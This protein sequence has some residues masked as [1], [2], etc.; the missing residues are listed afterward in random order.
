VA[1]K[2]KVSIIEV[3]ERAGVSKSTVSRV[4]SDGGGAVSARAHERVTNAIRE[5][6]YTR[7]T[8]A[9]GLRTQKTCIVLVMVPDIANPFWAEIA[10]AAQ[11]RLEADGNSVVVG[12]TDWTEEREKR[13]FELARAGR[14]DGIVLNSVTDN[15]AGI[16]ELGIPAVM[17]GERAA[18]QDIDTVGTDTR[19]ATRTALEYLW[20]TGHRRIAIATSEHGSERYLS[21]RR[22]AYE[23][24]LSERGI[25]ADPAI[26]F[27]VKL[28]DEGGRAFARSLLALP[29]WRER[30]DAVFCG[31]D[32]LAIAAM[33][34]LRDAG[35]QPGRDISV[36]GMDDIPAAALVRPALTT[37]RK[38]RSRIGAAAA[39]L[40]LA[41]IREP[42][43]PRVRTLFPGELVARESVVV[44]T[45]TEGQPRL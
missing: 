19:A 6:G 7:N 40:L 14:F 9:A 15:I 23:E 30:V 11:D 29:R 5:L 41:R 31:N 10:R 34:V 20:A 8:F 22:R 39:E 28:S 26:T 18:A 43:R 4:V 13:Y 38:P 2:R 27:S 33:E 3:A 1:K 25:T 36:V 16:H 45:A 21:L 12:N 35:V 44:R 32:L 42:E 24:F 17:V 37:V